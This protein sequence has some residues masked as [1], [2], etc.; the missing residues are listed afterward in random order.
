MEGGILS[1][2]APNKQLQENYNETKDNLFIPFQTVN[3]EGFMIII[4]TMWRQWATADNIIKAAKRVGIS[5]KGLNVDDMQQE[6]FSQAAIFMQTT[7]STDSSPPSTP[8]QPRRLSS[9]NSRNV[10][11]TPRSQLE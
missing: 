11:S 7:N 1:Y 3:R 2:Q 5:A 8:V 6:K 9:S 10:P 4:G